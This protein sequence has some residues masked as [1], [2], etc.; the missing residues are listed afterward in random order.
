MMVLN[1]FSEKNPELKQYVEKFMNDHPALLSNPV[2]IN[3]LK[4][5]KNVH[6]L[7]QAMRCPTKENIAYLDEAFREF[8][9]KIRWIAF[10]SQLLYYGSIDYDKKHRKDRERYPLILDKPLQGDQENDG[11]LVDLIPSKELSIEEMIIEKGKS[12]EEICGHPFLLQAIKELT[13]KE[14]EIIKLAYIED[15]TDKKIA[16]KLDV[17]PQAI[18]KTRKKAI[19]KLRCRIGGKNI[20]VKG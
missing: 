12:L 11:V 4:E 1:E 7:I 18:F 10:A 5:E 19:H 15:L 13:K 16:E 2:I 6:L 9:L 14:K 8:Y 3:F 17:S 20:W